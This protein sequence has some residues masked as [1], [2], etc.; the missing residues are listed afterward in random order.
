M[1]LFIGR[2]PIFDRSQRV[3]A[4]ELLYR[5][6]RTNAF[7]GLDGNEATSRLLFNVFNSPSLDAITGGR[8][9]FVNFTRDLLLSGAPVPIAPEL[10]TVEILEDME[11]DRALIAACRD[12]LR[13]GYRLALD[14]FV[15]TD[16]T[17]ELVPLASV[18]KVDWRATPPERVRELV[19]RL[20][21]RNLA[22]LAEKIETRQEFDQARA[23]GFHY[24]Q[25]FFFRR[26]VILQ[27][28][29]VPASHW[30]YLQILQALQ[31]PRLDF[32]EVEKIVAADATLTLKLLRYINSAAFALQS[33]ISSIRQAIVLL[34]ER[35][36]RQWLSLFVMARMGDDKPRENVTLACIRARCGELLARRRRQADKAPSVFL[37]GVLSVLDTLMGRPLAELLEGLP[38][39]PDIVEALLRARGP[40][41]DYLRLIIAYERGLWPSVERLAEGMGLDP[42]EVT[43]TYL[44][45][46]KWAEEFMQVA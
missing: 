8:R 18:I 16:A 36:V 45:A 23:M 32:A 12:L 4:Y 29:E 9:V 24:F 17:A 11:V 22:L 25:G 42:A 38:L 37:L 5:S 19:A 26:P 44:E 33:K 3:V 27:R 13:R 28:T 34:G 10:L 14:D 7:P 21:G 1:D 20:S 43:E 46:I 40:L 31:H 35:N 15:L 41:A 30:S 39:D 2:Q 6:G